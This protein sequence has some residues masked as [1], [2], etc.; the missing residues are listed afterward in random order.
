MRPIV[1]WRPCFWWRPCQAYLRD[2]F[3]GHTL[4]MSCRTL[5]TW[6]NAVHRFLKTCPLPTWSKL[7]VGAS[8]N[9]QLE[10]MSRLR[11]APWTWRHVP[12]QIKL[13]VLILPIANLTPQQVWRTIASMMACRVR[14]RLT[15]IKNNT[16]RKS[17]TTVS[18]VLTL[19][20]VKCVVK[21][22]VDFQTN[23]S[24]SFAI[25]TGG[26]VSRASYARGSV[27]SELCSHCQV[28]SSCDHG[29]WTCPNVPNLK[30]R[31]DKPSCPLQARLGWPSTET[32]NGDA[33][34]AWRCQVRKFQLNQHYKPP[35]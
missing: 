26:Y 7:G 17:E 4:H 25:L 1:A 18:C 27:C 3:Q 10:Q 8:L 24:H 29:F 12:S 11:I 33:V 14:I 34:F 6:V 13:L 20:I 9:K 23:S 28:V 2:I 32:N 22:R 16:K 30:Q 19:F 31:P 15:S 5:Q 35:T 21:P